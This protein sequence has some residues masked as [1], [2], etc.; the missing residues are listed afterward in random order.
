MCVC[1]CVINAYF[2]IFLL[3]TYVFNFLNLLLLFPFSFLFPPF[4]SPFLFF[5]SLRFFSLLFSSLFSSFLRIYFSLPIT[6]IASFLFFSLF[7]FH[8]NPYVINSLFFFLS[9]FLSSFYII[10][11]FPLLVYASFTCF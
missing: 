3:C 2:L 4:S 10:I 11:F 7:A 1:V 8:N 9:P 6:S 5:Y